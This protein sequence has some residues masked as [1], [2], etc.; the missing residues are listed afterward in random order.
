MEIPRKI[1][2]PDHAS[3]ADGLPLLAGQ[4]IHVGEVIL[5]RALV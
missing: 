3:I 2:N 4:R 1:Q 5:D